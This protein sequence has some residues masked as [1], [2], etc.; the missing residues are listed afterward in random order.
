M[1][2]ARATAQH[3]DKLW[4]SKVPKNKSMGSAAKCVYGGNT[5]FCSSWNMTTTDRHGAKMT[6]TF[7]VFPLDRNFAEADTALR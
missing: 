1:C 5:A 7:C 6:T 2:G 3:K 4:K